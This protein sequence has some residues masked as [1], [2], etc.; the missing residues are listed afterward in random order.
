[1]QEEMQPTMQ[2]PKLQLRDSG[3]EPL[4]PAQSRQRRQKE[5]GTAGIADAK[6]ALEVSHSAGIQ[7]TAETGANLEAC[8]IA[9]AQTADLHQIT[10]C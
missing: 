4:T 2:T 1:M 9:F 8:E 10:Y 3:G 6:I 5:A 7:K